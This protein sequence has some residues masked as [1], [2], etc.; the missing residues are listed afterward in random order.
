MQFS[1]YRSALGE[2]SG[3]QSA[4]YRRME[5]LLGEKSA[6]MLVPQR[7]APHE[8]QPLH[9]D[10][11]IDVRPD[12]FDVQLMYYPQQVTWERGGTLSVPGSHLRRTNESDTGRHQNLR[13]QDRLVCPAGTVVFLRHGLWHGGPGGR[14]PLGAVQPRPAVARADRRRRIRHRTLGDQGHQPPRGGGRMTIDTKSPAAQAGSTPVLRQRVLVLY[15]STSAP[16]SPIVGWARY[17]GTGRTSPTTGDSDEPPYESGM[18]ALRDGWRLIQSAQPIPPGP[19]REYDVSFDFG[20]EPQVTGVDDQFM[21]GPALMACPVTRRSGSAPVR[22][23]PQTRGVL[24]PS[25]TD[26]VDVWDGTRHEGRRRIEAPTPVEKPPVYARAGSVVP[27]ARTE[28][29]WDEANG[30]LPV[31]RP[32]GD[33]PGRPVRR[34]VRAR[35]VEPGRGW[36]GLGWGQASALWLIAEQQRRKLRIPLR[37][38]RSSSRRS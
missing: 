25:G 17:D 11:L 8:A 37:P 12:A 21:W 6:P 9:A 32:V 18:E 15:L 35:L 10:A 34:V 24:L 26:W 1:S 29:R 5:F 22:D 20:H 14:G 27:C 38:S 13:G 2:G 3:F 19:G 7:G 31:G 16:D 23:A 33:H 30:A 4:M 28:L 36:A